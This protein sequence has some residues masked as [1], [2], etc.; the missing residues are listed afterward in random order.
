MSKCGDWIGYYN[1][2][3]GLVP[4]AMELSLSFSGSSLSGRGIDDVGRFTI[5][6]TYSGDVCSW[7]KTYS[8]HSVQ[9]TGYLDGGHIW[10]TWTLAWESGGFTIRP[11]PAREAKFEQ[12]VAVERIAV[13]SGGKPGIR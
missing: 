9:Y 1:Y 13:L 4:H 5:G 7:I 2:G 12:V 8:S 3:D 10:G 11:K 6:G